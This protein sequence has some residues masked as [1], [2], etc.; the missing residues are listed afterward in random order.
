MCQGK[1]KTEKPFLQSL[2]QLLFIDQLLM[3][4][5]AQEQCGTAGTTGITGTTVTTG[6]MGVTGIIGDDKISCS[7]VD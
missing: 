3:S 4:C 6:A 5:R 1:F 2:T 7:H